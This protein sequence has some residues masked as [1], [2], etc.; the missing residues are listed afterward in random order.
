[1]LLE[2]LAAIAVYLAVISL[3]GSWFW[4]FISIVFTLMV[5]RFTRPKPKG[6]P[7]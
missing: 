7:V 3:T 6:P 4:G 2:A 1:M 5:L